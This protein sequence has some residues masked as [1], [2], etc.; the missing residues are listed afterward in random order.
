MKIDNVGLK[1][2]K[3]DLISLNSKYRTNAGTNVLKLIKKTHLSKLA[4]YMGNFGF[5]YPLK[6][7]TTKK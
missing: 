2:W 7:I 4:S 6:Y 5:Y 1:E 3:K